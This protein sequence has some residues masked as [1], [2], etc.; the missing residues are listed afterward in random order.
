MLKINQLLSKYFSGA[1]SSSI[2]TGIILTIIVAY[3]LTIS[4]Y[5]T[6]FYPWYAN[7]E[8]FP[9]I[10]EILRFVTFDFRQEFFDIPGTPLMMIGTFLWSIYYWVCAFFSHP[11]TGQAIR[12]FSFKNIQELY[13][14]MRVLSYFFYVLSILL[15][16][17]IAHRL[18]NRVGGLVAALLLSLAH[19][20]PNNLAFMD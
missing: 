19:L 14:L 1:N 18:T 5:P 3:S 8:E 13:L 12:Y 20:L 7:T 10:Q 2:F 11:D 4:A 6:I 9:Y 16:Y 15:T 17:F